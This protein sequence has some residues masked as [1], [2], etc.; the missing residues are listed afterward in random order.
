VYEGISCEGDTL[1][2]C[3]EARVHRR[4]CAAIGEGFSCHTV[5][6]AT[7][8][9]LGADCVPGNQPGYPPQNAAPITCN[10]SVLNFCNAGR[11]DQIDCT[12]LGFTGCDAG[13][14]GCT[15]NFETEF[16]Q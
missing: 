15:P 5:D 13:F 8:C 7:F 3:V 9:G 6:G 12:D 2:S 4:D 14:S 10:G 16:A 1:V 11:L